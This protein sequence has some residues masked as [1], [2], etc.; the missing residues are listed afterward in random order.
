MKGSRRA[1]TFVWASMLVL[2]LAFAWVAFGVRDAPDAGGLAA[3]LFWIAAAVSAVNLVLSR[4]LP[5]RLRQGSSDPAAVAFTRLLVAWALCEAAALAPVVAFILTRDPRLLGLLG[6]DLLAL[7]LLYPGD[8][9]WESV[10]PAAA[11][12]AQGRTVR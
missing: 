1:A 3:T 10:L 4:A 5:P 12:R 9:R 2:P 8:A 7:A 11:G 6:V